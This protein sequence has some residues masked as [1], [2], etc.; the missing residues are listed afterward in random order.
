LLSAPRRCYYHGVGGTGALVDI[1][2]GVGG[3]GA[4]VLADSQGVGGTGALVLATLGWVTRA[5]RPIAL[6]RTNRT[7]TV[8]TIHLFI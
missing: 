5:F 4:D 1:I 8:T 3:T 2:H 6:V 7:R